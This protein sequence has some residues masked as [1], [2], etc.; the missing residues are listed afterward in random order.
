MES[1]ANPGQKP[2]Q[3]KERRREPRRNVDGTAVLHILNLALHMPGRILNLSMGGCGIRTDKRFML[4]IYRR[5]EVEF[6][7]EGLPFRLAGVTQFIQGHHNVG[8]RFLDIS[9]RKR[10]QLIELIKELD[11]YLKEQQENEQAQ[12]EQTSAP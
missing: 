4:G 11:E 1:E 2:K 9:E 6:R 10:E 8:I 7:L 12:G 5:V 3:R